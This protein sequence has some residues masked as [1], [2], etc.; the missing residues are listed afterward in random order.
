M[1]IVQYLLL[2][3]TLCAGQLVFAQEPAYNWGEPATNDFS[4][5]QIDKLLALDNGGFVLLRKYTDPTFTNSYWLEYYSTELKLEG[6][7]EVAFQGGVMGDA[8]FLDEIMV[9]NGVIYAFVSHWNKAA[10]EHTLMLKELTFSGELNDIATLDVIK[11]QKMGNRGAFRYALSDDHSK[12]GLLSEMPF[13]KKT[14]EK[15]RLKSFDLASA[16]EL[17]TA[18]QELN[19]DSKRAVN[20]EVAVDN[21]GQ[22][23]LFKKIW[24]KPAWQ[25]NLYAAKDGVWEDYTSLALDGKEIIDYQMSF[26]ASNEF[27]MFATYSTNSSA[28]EKKL[29]GSAFYR[30][31]KNL[32]LASASAGPWFSEM[33]TYFLGERAG[34]KPEAHLS[35][36]NIKDVLLR[37]DGKILVLMEQLKEDK[38]PIVGSSPIQYI[39]EWNYGAF[40]ALCLDPNSGDLQWWQTFDKSQELKNSSSVDEY[41]SFVYTLKEDRLYVLWNN[42]RLSVPSIPAANW[43][44]PDGTKYVK[45]KA[46]DEKTMHASFMQVIEPDGFLAYENR[47]FGLPLFELHDGAVFEMSL[48]SPFFFT[49]N[50]NLVV[51]AS[52]HNGGKRYRFGIIGL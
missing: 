49:S 32:S 46:F 50:G 2:A 11:A 44:E 10:G 48:T 9:A 3:C 45:H 43:T 36:F 47:K 37:E 13:T 30:I 8:Y 19:W 52:M 26:N 1:K 6:N 22:V 29:Q 35:N 40:M 21:D 42:T 24:L 41:G 20:N 7:V 33:L 38:E 18:D 14:K 34:S 31:D 16:K 4:E 39:Y 12:L 51:M 25:Y 5:R 23:Y 27:V 17:W 15:L 28:Y